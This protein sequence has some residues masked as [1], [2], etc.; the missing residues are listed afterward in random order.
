MD[1]RLAK[2]LEQANYSVA[3]QTQK[4]NLRLA[5]T[6]ALTFGHNGGTF[7]A[8]EKLISFIDALLRADN[9]SEV[10]IDERGNPVMIDDLSAFYLRVV[11]TYRTAANEFYAGYEKLRRARTTKAAVG[12]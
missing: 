7:V 10:V 2:A 8:S 4:R 12:V 11:E 3:I 1:D 9:G 6:N 5:F